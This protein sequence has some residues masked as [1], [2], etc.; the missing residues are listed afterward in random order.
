MTIRKDWVKMPSELT[1]DRRAWSASFR[2]V[3]NAIGD[4]GATRPGW[5]P[6]QLQKHKVS[7]CGF[8]GLINPNS[9]FYL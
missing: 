3:V 8:F 1:Q 7:P 4:A 5:M 2:D 9:N 6:T